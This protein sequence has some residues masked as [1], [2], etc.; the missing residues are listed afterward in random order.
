MSD[1]AAVFTRGQLGE[2]RRSAIFKEAVKL[3][4]T[5]EQY[6]AMD[7][8]EVVEW[9]LAH[10][11]GGPEHGTSVASVDKSKADPSTDK[12]KEEPKKRG[13][14][15]GAR[16]RGSRAAEEKA[17]EEKAPEEKAAEPPAAGGGGCDLHPLLDRISDL[18]K[19]QAAQAEQLRVFA[20]TEND[21]NAKLFDEI[22]E[23]R[24]DM[25][26]VKEIVKA[27][28][29]A[30]ENPAAAGKHIAELEAQVSGN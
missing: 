28:Y 3:G 22:G 6:Q 14:P 9:Y 5:V 17:P 7:F 21:N 23:L 11:E 30:V 26:I 16:G 18:I 15:R 4:L 27:I 2:M 24:A 20:A 25:F 10:Q 19:E 29:E 8:P 12:S 13:A 1:S